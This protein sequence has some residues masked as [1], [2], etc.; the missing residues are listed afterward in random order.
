[1]AEQKPVESDYTTQL[2]MPWIVA[3]AVTVVVLLVG[4][5]G[6]ALF[7]HQLVKNQEAAAKVVADKVIVDM[8]KQDTAAILR[9]SDVAFQ[10]KY[11]AS[12]LSDK[13][14]FNYGNNPLKFSEVYGNYKPSVDR[15]IVANNAKGQHTS[16]IYVY[17]KLKVPF[18]VRLDL[19][20]APGSDTWKLNAL[21]ANSDESKL[22]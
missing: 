11:T 18:Y 8:S 17:Q 19:T 3:M 21:S 1:M 14:T 12:E 4:G 20:K 16:F 10:K 15:S 7:R 5:I 22:Q 6:I 9:R 2:S 13:L